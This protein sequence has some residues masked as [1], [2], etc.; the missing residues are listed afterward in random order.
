MSF[1][2]IVL[3]FESKSMVALLIGYWGLKELKKIK[4]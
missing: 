4:Q 1:F 2:L 3:I